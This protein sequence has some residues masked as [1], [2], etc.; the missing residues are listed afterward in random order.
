MTQIGEELTVNLR[1]NGNGRFEKTT[2]TKRKVKQVYP[3][4]RVRDTAGDVWFV[5]RTNQG[6][7]TVR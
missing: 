5:K 4:G 2:A 1:Y 7:I 3:D 6:L